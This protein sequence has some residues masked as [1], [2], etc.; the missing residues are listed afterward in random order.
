MALDA[1][2]WNVATNFKHLLQ[3]DLESLF[4]ML[5]TLCT[6]TNGP[7]CLC[8][9]IPGADE[10]SICL[11]EWWAIYDHHALACHKAA[12]L[13]SFNEF[14][15]QCLLSYWD[16]FHQVLRDL[17]S[18]VWAENCAVLNQPNAATHDA[19]LEVLT[20]ARDIYLEKGEE[21]YVFAPIVEKRAGQSGLQK[22][23]ENGG[24]VSEDA[25][26]RKRHIGTTITLSRNKQGQYVDSGAP[27]TAEK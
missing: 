26:R 6:Y 17:H 23:K 22:R 13:S 10:L 3:H 20:K 11:N 8:S 4:Y 1:L 14:I 16:D 24:D 18:V 19:F 2:K 5:I 15:L 25:K 12:M 27:N 9:A 21:A 7:G